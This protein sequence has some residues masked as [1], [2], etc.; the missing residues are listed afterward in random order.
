MEPQ[1]FIT[2]RHFCRHYQVPD[3]FIESLQEYEL[4]EV[5]TDREEPCIPTKQI[6]EIEKIMRL[7]YDLEINL[8]GVDAIYHLLRK[9]ENLQQRVNQLHTRLGLYED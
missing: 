8:A 2:I 6:S 5:I 9:V 4:I 7:H 1:E 3:T